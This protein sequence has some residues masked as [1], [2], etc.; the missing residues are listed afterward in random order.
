LLNLSDNFKNDIILTGQTLT[1]VAVITDQNDNILYTF[2]TH[3]LKITNVDVDPILKDVSKIKINTDYDKKNIKANTLRANIYNYYDTKDRLTDIFDMV[4]KRIYLFYK[5]PLTRTINFTDEINNT[6]CA[7]VY[8]GRITRVEH[9]QQIISILAEDSTQAKINNKSVPYM[10]QDKLS[11]DV[12]DRILEE[13]KDDNIT[14]PMVFGSV[15]KAPVLPYLDKNND[16]VMN[17]LF[18][19]H[20]TSGHFK[21]SKIPSVADNILPI[22]DNNYYLYIKRDKDFIIWNHVDKTFNYQ[23][24]TYSRVRVHNYQGSTD[25]YLLNQLQDDAPED[26]GLWDV[27]AFAERQVESATTGDNSILDIRNLI[28]G[29]SEESGGSLDYLNN[30]AGYKK[31]FYR[32]TDPIANHDVSEGYDTDISGFWFQ[33]EIYTQA[34]NSAGDGRFILLKL[35]KGV[36]DRLRCMKQDGVFIGNTFLLSNFKIR[37]EWDST[38]NPHDDFFVFGLPAEVE[39]A[40]FHV[41]PIA[42]DIWRE[43]VPEILSRITSEG[44][45]DWEDLILHLLIETEE[46]LMNHG[47]PY[48]ADPLY[49]YAPEPFAYQ[50]SPIRMPTQETTKHNREA[51]YFSAN[52]TESGHPVVDTDKLKKIQGLYY[53]D[54]GTDERVLLPAANSHDYIA[55][56]EYYPRDWHDADWHHRQRLTINNVGFLQS[57]HAENIREDEIFASIVGRKSHYYTEEILAAPTGNNTPIVPELIELI[58]GNDNAYPDF[59]ALIESYYATLQRSL[60]G[61]YDGGNITLLNSELNSNFLELL[62][63]SWSEFNNEDD[64]AIYRNFE[65]YK[66]F[67]YSV[68]KKIFE[69]MYYMYYRSNSMQSL[70]NENVPE[71]EYALVGIFS[72]NIVKAV[73]KRMLEYIYQTDIDIDIPFSLEYVNPNWYMSQSGAWWAADVYSSEELTL[74]SIDLTDSINF[75]Y[76]WDFETNEDGNDWMNN[77][78]TFIDDT[79]YSINYALYDALS[80]EISHAWQINENNNGGFWYV[81]YYHNDVNEQ[82]QQFPQQFSWSN[83]QNTNEITNTILES[84]YMTWN[85]LQ[86]SNDFATTTDGIIEKPSDI[87]MN[88]MCYELGYGRRIKNQDIAT[89][90]NIAPDY[91]QF[92]MESIEKSRNAHA[93]FKMGFAI[94]EQM[95]SKKLIEGILQESKSYP[96]FSSDGKFGLMTIKE[97][98]TLED[99]DREI[100]INDVLKHKISKTKQEDLMTSCKMMYRFNNG[101][102]NYDMETSTLHIEEL[103]VDY[104]GYDS[105][106]ITQDEGH[107]DIK[108]RY[109]TDIDTVNEFQ[110]Y[111]LLNECNVHNLIDLTL[112]LSYMDL[113]MGDIIHIPLNPNQNS[114]GI[115][116][117]KVTYLNGQ[118]VY[119]LFMIMGITISSNSVQITGYQ[120]HYLGTDGDHK[121]GV[122]YDIVG[123]TEQINTYGYQLYDGSGNTS[124]P[125]NYDPIA[126]WNYNPLATVHN[127]IE[128]PF[129]D[130]NGDGIIN[131]IDIID[132]ANHIL[133]EAELTDLQKE[134]LSNINWVRPV[135]PDVTHITKMTYIILALWND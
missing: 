29:Q 91:N 68:N 13:Y 37:C 121:F 111:K 115:D 134:R 58:K 105:Y 63:Q 103:L 10:T 130:I 23:D 80:S 11:N 116:F 18:D 74:E 47:H 4:S 86:I 123:C 7:L 95:D 27:H 133:G 59:N 15:D 39:Y 61:Y 36:N 3:N 55:I 112:P 113:N 40:G 88:I 81:T 85:S 117:S 76:N 62:Q 8:K 102:D 1:P 16:R 92:D 26:V 94:N 96:T 110:K 5:S 53:G 52:N 122:D 125:S 120:L 44:D 45:Q 12:K 28:V 97:S 21:T 54:T 24:Y 72:S 106:G 78:V 108:L 67:I 128:I 69:I 14:I 75:Q 99:I 34:D 104:T 127:N 82:V 126:N 124:H 109:H 101:T 56:F 38:M 41:A 22:D 129:Y 6:D 42:I 100:D 98:Y 20:P 25:Q 87:V 79:I 35:D 2:S 131:V 119:P 48:N 71:R 118:H 19:I 60:E 64:S 77:L 65:L 17:L 31:I 50:N 43:R 107:K 132:V 51:K 46:D 114:Y 66:E 49:D 32:A 89:Q 93:G 73:T 84:L 9:N 30:N 90:Y 70:L 135:E 57:V 33:Q 83:N